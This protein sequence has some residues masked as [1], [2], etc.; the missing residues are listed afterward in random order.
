MNSFLPQDSIDKRKSQAAPK[1]EIWSSLL[2][3]VSSGKRLPEKQLILLGGTPESQK[4]FL[5]SLSPESAANRKYNS[6]KPPVANQYALGYTY[7]DVMDAD[8]ADT[9]ARLS[10]YTLADASPTLAPLLTPLLTPKTLPNTLVV[11]LLD[12]SQPWNWIRQLRAWIRLLRSV[13]VSL[14]VESKQAMEDNVVYWRDT[15]R[16]T[17]LEGSNPDEESALPPGPGEWDEPLGVPL[18]VVCQNTDKMQT[19]EKEQGW[20]DEQFDYVGQYV[21]TIL[22]KHGG[23]LIYTMPSAPGSLQ[24]LIHASL[25]IQSTLQK[26]ELKYEVTNRDKTLVPPNWDSWSKIRIM[27]DNFDAE[28]ISEMWSHDI[29][30]NGQTEAIPEASQEEESEPSTAVSLY[31]EEIRNPKMDAILPGLTRKPESGIE[32]ESEDVQTF[33][34]EQAKILEKLQEEDKAEKAIKDQKQP[35]SKQITPEGRGDVDKHI[36]PVQYNVGGINLDL[37]YTL[38]Q[39]K[40][41]ESAR[42]AEDTPKSPLTQKDSVDENARLSDFFAK[43]A[44]KPGASATNTPRR[45]ET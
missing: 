26:K 43:L 34:A 27:A 2:N 42:A 17:T 32:V 19:L 3:S 14:D 45:T 9:L 16:S 37:D 20:K 12:W 4:E 5:E 22:L 6:K 18:C 41:R 21:R 39:I 44:R 25:G 31:E 29:Q 11:V 23:S 7:Q 33:L 10:I 1:K 28:V 30:V 38:S 13:V 40:E 36:G 15:K 35:P 8:Q 24:I